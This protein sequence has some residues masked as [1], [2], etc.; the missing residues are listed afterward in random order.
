MKM[1]SMKRPRPS[2]EIATPAVTSLLVK[3][4]A[5]KVEPWTVLKIRGFGSHLLLCQTD[6]LSDPCQRTLLHAPSLG[7]VRR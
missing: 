2:I 5:V 4:S 3:A 6:G 1:L 7:G